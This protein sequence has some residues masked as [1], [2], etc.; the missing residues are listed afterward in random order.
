LKSGLR[1]HTQSCVFQRKAA[2]ESKEAG[3]EKPAACHLPRNRQPPFVQPTR[4]SWLWELLPDGATVLDD[5]RARRVMREL[6]RPLF[7]NETPILFTGR[8]SAGL[9]KYASNAFLATKTT[10]ITEAQNWL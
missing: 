5:E 7:I 3:Q 6:Y 2:T 9:I 10:F 1:G 8:R 4:Y